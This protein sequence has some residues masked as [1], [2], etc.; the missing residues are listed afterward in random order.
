M[1]SIEQGRLFCNLEYV[2]VALGRFIDRQA[3]AVL[4]NQFK[5]YYVA[6]K[7]RTFQPRCFEATTECD[8][9]SYQELSLHVQFTA[10]NCNLVITNDFII[11]T[12]SFLTKI[13]LR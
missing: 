1:A 12:K 9:N 7:Y 10:L 4:G 11:V 2:K 8:Q 5:Q 3:V 6:L 13:S